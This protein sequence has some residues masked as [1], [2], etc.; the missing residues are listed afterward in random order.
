MVWQTA[1]RLSLE[2]DRFATLANTCGESSVMSKCMPTSS[3]KCMPSSD[4][5]F[6]R[7][8]V[9]ATAAA[10][11]LTPFQW[12]GCKFLNLLLLCLKTV[13]IWSTAAQPSQHAVAH[14]LIGPKLAARFGITA[15][16]CTAAACIT[17]VGF[18]PAVGGVRA[19]AATRVAS[20]IIVSP[21]PVISHPYIMAGPAAPLTYST[22]LSPS[23]PSCWILCTAFLV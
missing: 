18:F 14:A 8:Q 4:L 9:A 13:N 15:S 21:I 12:L 11:P 19:E 20:S 1:F 10:G 3:R 17:I 22:T 23:L 5:H 2:T 6:S 16:E 7:M